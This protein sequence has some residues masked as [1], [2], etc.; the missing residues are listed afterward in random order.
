MVYEC[1]AWVIWGVGFIMGFGL[2]PVG[3]VALSYFVREVIRVIYE[4]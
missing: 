4:D 1:L 2:V 3:I